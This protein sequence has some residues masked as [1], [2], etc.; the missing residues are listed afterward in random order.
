MDSA[1]EAFG[2]SLI[3]MRPMDPV[4]ISEAAWILGCSRSTVQRM[5]QDGRLPAGDPYIHGRLSKNDVEKVS[6]MVYPWRRHLHDPWSYWVTGQDAADLLGIGQKRL[7]RLALANR[8]PYVR[9]RDGTRLYRR[10]QLKNLARHGPGVVS[11]PGST[12]S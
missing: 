5:M 6:S 9:H 1:L 3:A 10:N 12:A 7:E 2:L 11:P 4:S 8:V